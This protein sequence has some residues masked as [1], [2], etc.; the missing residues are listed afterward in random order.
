MTTG[1][2]ISK[3]AERSR[4]F[5]E[6]RYESRTLLA[7]ANLP[8]MLATLLV[9]GY[10][11][12][13]FHLVED[14]VLGKSLILCVRPIRRAVI[15]VVSSSMHLHR[16]RPLQFVLLI[17]IQ[18]GLR[19]RFSYRRQRLL[20]HGILL[21]RV[22]SAEEQRVHA[23][24]SYKATP[25]KLPAKQGRPLRLSPPNE[26]PYVVVSR[27]LTSD[28]QRRIHTSHSSE[29]DSSFHP[30]PA[31]IRTTRIRRWICI[32]VTITSTVVVTLISFP[33]FLYC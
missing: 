25:T 24:C 16:R 27:F 3:S 7:T 33:H 11:C 17:I 4:H 2:M 6:G 1:K 22:T 8:A 18:Q 19:L 12:R 30:R 15:N 21:I 29:S 26:I 23:P 10:R 14:T 20:H 9:S 32:C 28:R 13:R 31:F 5:R